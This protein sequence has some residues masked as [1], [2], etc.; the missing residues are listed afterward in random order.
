MNGSQS[1][2]SDRLNALQMSWYIDYDIDPS[3]AP[4][5]S[6]KVPYIPVILGNRIPEG[7]LTDIA[8]N[9]P[10]EYWYIGGEPNTRGISGTAFVPEFDYYVGI[11]K[12]AD[13]TA[14]IV[15]ASILNWDFTCTGCGGFQSGHSWLQEF[16]TAYQNAHD[17][18]LPPIDVWAI[19]AYPLT[20][21]KVPMV[22]WFTV[23]QQ[24]QGL[25]NFLDF[26][27][28]RFSDP[29]WITE[30]GTHWAYDAW[31]IGPTG[32]LTIPSHLDWVDDYRWDAVTKY[33]E[34]LIRWLLIN[35]Q[36]LKIEKWFFFRDWIDPATH[37]GADANYS[38]LYLFE[39]KDLDS[40]LN[41]V[42]Q[43]YFD[44]AQLNK[45]A[46]GGR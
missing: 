37:E 3:S 26:E 40:P 42:G 32:D 10:G 15:S 7:V 5:G 38:G 23:V 9:S 17:G 35:S 25:R 24:I 13:P 4:P 12:S 45:A 22:D 46:F 8:R 44:Y 2:V 21:D 20:W 27:L 43:L 31:E 19:D 39:S 1:L 29:I 33:T 41:P 14:K 36:S 11:I 34:S 6:T 28:F 18:V 16:I 30:A